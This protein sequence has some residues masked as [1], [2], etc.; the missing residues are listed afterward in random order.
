ME[1]L[2]SY[3]NKPKHSQF[4]GQ[5]GVHNMTSIVIEGSYDLRWREPVWVGSGYGAPEPVRGP[6]QAISYLIFRWPTVSSTVVKRARS[7]C[8][9]ALQKQLT[10]EAAR[11]AF[12]RAAEEAH[13]LVNHGLQR[14]QQVA[15]PSAGRTTAP[16][17]PSCHRLPHLPAKSRSAG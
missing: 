3:R 10:C 7:K 1:C 8:L 12:V 15:P 11:E 17:T 6:R 5:H 14:G 9:A 2:Q 16:T 4:F 13:I